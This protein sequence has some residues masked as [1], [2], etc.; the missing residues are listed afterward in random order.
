MTIVTELKPHI[1]QLAILEPSAAP[2]VSCCLNLERGPSGFREVLK[3]RVRMLRASLTEA[4][5]ELEDALER[6]NAFIRTE[7][8]LEA[9]GIA[10]WCGSRNG[11]ERA[12]RSSVTVISSR[13]SGESAPCCGSCRHIANGR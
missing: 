8:V 5:V 9:K 6:I 7:L 2:V 13:S 3:Q 1:R 4:S 12:W 11:V 10:R